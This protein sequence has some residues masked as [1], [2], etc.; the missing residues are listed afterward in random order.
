MTPQIGKARIQTQVCLS[1]FA[2]YSCHVFSA[3][4]SCPR[5]SQC[6]GLT[7][8]ACFSQGPSFCIWQFARKKQMQE[9]AELR[10]AVEVHA[11]PYF[12]PV[13]T[14]ISMMSSCSCL[15][16]YSE[17]N[18]VCRASR[19]PFGQKNHALPGWLIDVW[20]STHLASVPL[21]PLCSTI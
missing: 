16:T 12:S 4:H 11:L 5:L 2:E 14:F 7:S 9:D 15:F 3:C 6:L 13:G 21:C 1:A 8:I 20:S 10:R 18:P 17:R 19:T